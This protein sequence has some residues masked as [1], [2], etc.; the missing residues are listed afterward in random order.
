MRREEPVRLA[1]GAEP[2]PARLAAT[3]VVARPAPV[4][5]IEVLALRRSA[6]SRVLPGFVVFP[7]G[8]VDGDDRALA[9]RWFGSPGEA[10]RACAIRELAEEAS[11]ALTRSGLVAATTTDDAEALALVAAAPPGA[12]QVV[13]LARWLAPDF[14]PVRFDAHFFAV[15]VDRKVEPIADGVEIETAWWASPADLLAAFRVGDA[16]L[17]WPTYKTLETLGERCA[18]VDDVLALRMEPSPPPGFEQPGRA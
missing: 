2:A 5:G 18:T 12:D 9:E 1:E 17:A 10:P 11:L 15:G 7:G 16:P 4:D 13:P 14:L 3:V 6:S 8:T